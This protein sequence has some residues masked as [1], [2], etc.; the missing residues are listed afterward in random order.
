MLC[1]LPVPSALN[2]RPTH[3]SACNP[4]LLAPPAGVTSIEP[5]W[6]PDV[7][8]PLCTFS[9]PLAE[10]PAFYKPAADK[11]GRLEA[12]RCIA[13]GAATDLLAG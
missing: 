9:Q 12:G 1:T 7:A 4:S 6:L 10:P 11:V 8:A 3:S 2:L 13:Y 5:Q